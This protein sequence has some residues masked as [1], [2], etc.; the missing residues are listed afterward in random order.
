M[1]TR[2]IKE[3]IYSIAKGLAQW[4][5][6]VWTEIPETLHKGHLL[7]MKNALQSNTPPNNVFDLIK[8]LHEPVEK[9]EWMG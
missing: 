9:W 5:K 4:E 3:M 8:L 7:F 1:Q 6:K 2:E